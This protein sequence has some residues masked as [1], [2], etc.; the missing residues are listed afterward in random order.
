[1]NKQE[2]INYIKDMISSEYYDE[3]DLEERIDEYTIQILNE[4]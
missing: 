1:M 3:I 4:K 2:L